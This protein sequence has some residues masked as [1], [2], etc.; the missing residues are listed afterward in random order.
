[1]GMQ[2]TIAG[3][4]RLTADELESTARLAVF[5]FP[6]IS[7]CGDYRRGLAVSLKNSGER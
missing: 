1:M 5:V 3:N 4:H 2:V 7:S 6:A